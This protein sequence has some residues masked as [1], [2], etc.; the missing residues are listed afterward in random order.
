MNVELCQTI[1]KQDV[2]A[3]ALVDPVSSHRSSCTVHV[4]IVRNSKICDGILM[5][6]V[7]GGPAYASR[8]ADVDSRRCSSP[9]PVAGRGIGTPWA[10]AGKPLRARRLGGDAAARAAPAETTAG[11]RGRLIDRQCLTVN[12]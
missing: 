4:Q 7:Q 8:P 10:R 3:F 11:S 2:C 12:R 9:V 6:V 1:F 5:T